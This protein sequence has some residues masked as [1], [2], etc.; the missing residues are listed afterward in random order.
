M[1]SAGLN[2]LPMTSDDAKSWHLVARLG[3][4][5]RMVCGVPSWALGSGLWQFV[6]KNICS[7]TEKHLS[8]NKF[9][10]IS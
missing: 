9:L 1:A 2:V 5:K 7:M 4:E 3:W 8:W 10:K 6:L